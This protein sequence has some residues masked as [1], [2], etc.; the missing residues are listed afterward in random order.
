MDEISRNNI[1]N[2]NMVQFSFK[3]RSNLLRSRSNKCR[4]FMARSWQS[5]KSLW[6]LTWS[7]KAELEKSR[8]WKL[9]SR[10]VRSWKIS[11]FI[12]NSR[13]KLET[14]IYKWK[15]SPEMERTSWS[16][17]M[18]EWFKLAFPTSMRFSTNPFQ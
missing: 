6:E 9:L 13:A 10:K 5:Q 15:I 14:F 18:L 1:S 17:G 2:S 16:W 7:W 4:E 8:S 12:E 3:L 11:E